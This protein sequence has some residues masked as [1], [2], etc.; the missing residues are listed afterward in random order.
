MSRSK[1]TNSEK[2]ANQTTNRVISP[3]QNSP[4]AEPSRPADGDACNAEAGATPDGGAQESLQD[5]E[6][7][8]FLRKPGYGEGEDLVRSACRWF[9]IRSGS[10]DRATVTGVLEPYVSVTTSWSWLNVLEERAE[11]EFAVGPL[12]AP[13]HLRMP[14]AHP[15]LT[16]RDLADAIAALPTETSAPVGLP[17]GKAGGTL[18]RYRATITE[19]QAEKVRGIL[20][21][22]AEAARGSPEKAGWQLVAIGNQLRIVGNHDVRDWAL[23]THVRQLKAKQQE[24]KR[25]RSGRRGGAPAAKRAE[26]NVDN[27]VSLIRQV[28][29]CLASH[30]YLTESRGEAS[31]GWSNIPADWQAPIDAWTVELR[32][33]ETER[34]G[35]P[36]GIPSGLRIL[37]ELHAT[38]DGVTARG[39]EESWAKAMQLLEKRVDEH[40][41][42]TTQVTRARRAYVHLCEA[43]LIDG[44]PHERP[45][46]RK[47]TRAVSLRLWTEGECTAAAYAERDPVAESV[48][49]LTVAECLAA[50][51]AA[52]HPIARSIPC[53]VA[54]L[55]KYIGWRKDPNTLSFDG[56]TFLGHITRRSINAS[57]V[58]ETTERQAANI[59]YDIGGALARLAADGALDLATATLEDFI[60]VAAEQVGPTRAEAHPRLALLSKDLRS[61]GLLLHVVAQLATPFGSNMAFLDGKAPDVVKDLNQAGLDLLSAKPR[62]RVQRGK[63]R[64]KGKREDKHVRKTLEFLAPIGLLVAEGPAENRVYHFY[65][66][67]LEH[68][69]G[70]AHAVTLAVGPAVPGYTAAYLQNPDLLPPDAGL[71]YLASLRDWTR[72]NSLD[73][74]RVARSLRALLMSGVGHATAI[75]QLSFRGLELDE[76]RAYGGG[77]LFQFPAEKYKVTSVNHE[78]PVGRLLRADEPWVPGIL[79]WRL[80]EL[81]KQARPI[82]LTGPDGPH[83]SSAFFVPDMFDPRERVFE[84]IRLGSKLCTGVMLSEE[85]LARELWRIVRPLEVK[86]VKQFPKRTKPEYLWRHAVGTLTYYE[87]SPEAARI[88]LGHVNQEVTDR[89]YNGLLPREADSSRERGGYAERRMR[90]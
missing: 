36:N 35:D 16:L 8:L 51:D 47:Y 20:R 56:D 70:L 71:A 38:V 62:Q 73:T 11:I 58:H 17:P 10:A 3:S 84:E 59:L 4:A 24:L 86:G 49:G 90:R 83:E 68:H 88:L 43:G 87:V 44:L 28:L 67:L 54:V 30:G 63:K 18:I 50:Y 26:R 32:R 61:A 27:D 22:I 75:R 12:G 40:G 37:I 74:R 1:K 15:L 89:H 85:G 60:R 21:L 42:S 45:S 77:L 72:D 64:R 6:S 69:V 48:E 39:T 5:K 80:I 13:K 34:V 14:G 46:D 23:C 9:T 41:Y 57:A 29:N 81:Y 55:Q 79:E 53:L 65:D 31:V 7:A 82:L 78:V 2:G 33:L 25:G 66:R 76:V 19:S 52:W